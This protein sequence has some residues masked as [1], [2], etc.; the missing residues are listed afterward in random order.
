M[1]SIVFAMSTVGAI[2]AIFV[3]H[4]TI[5]IIRKWLEA[6][7]F[8]QRGTESTARIL[9]AQVINESGRYLPFVRLKLEVMANAEKSF[10]TEAD[11]FFSIPELPA[12]MNGTSIHVMYNPENLAQVTVVKK[13]TV[14]N[15]AEHSWQPFVDTSR[16]A[17]AR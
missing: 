9:Q 13:A 16:L 7:K 14:K 3:L 2:A 11:S 15:R 1:N 10:I 4:F 6:R 8:R 17:L 12:L 5:Y